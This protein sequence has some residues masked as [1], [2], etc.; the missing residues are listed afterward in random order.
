[1]KLKI[2]SFIS[3]GANTIL[4]FDSIIFLI[5]V[6]GNRKI[7]KLCTNSSIILWRSKIVVLILRCTLKP[8]YTAMLM[9]LQ[10]LAIYPSCEEKYKETRKSGHVKS[11][12]Y[13]DFAVTL[14]AVYRCWALIAWTFALLRAIDI[15]IQY[16][17]YWKQLSIPQ[18][19]ENGSDISICNT[20]RNIRTRWA[21]IW[22]GVT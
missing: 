20:T 3:M 11:W 22:D 15:C 7:E 17:K 5:Y 19:M 18:S 14:R 4:S 21:A 10:I 16:F 6:T 2:Q 1:M 8:R 13:V 9:T 12:R